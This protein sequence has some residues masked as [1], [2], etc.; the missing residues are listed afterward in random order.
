MEQLKSAAD[1]DVPALL[2]RLGVGK[3]AISDT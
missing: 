3:K 2:T 1:I